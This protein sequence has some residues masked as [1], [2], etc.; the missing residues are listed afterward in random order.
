MT[1]NDPAPM[2]NGPKEVRVSDPKD[3]GGDD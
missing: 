1:T 3:D 2:K